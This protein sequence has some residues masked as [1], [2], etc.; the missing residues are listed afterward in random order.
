M[1]SELKRIWENGLDYRL[2]FSNKELSNEERRHF[3]VKCIEEFESFI[4]KK[5]LGQTPK[6][7]QET[8]IAF[9]YSGDAYLFLGN[10]YQSAEYYKFARQFST[11]RDKETTQIPKKEESNISVF[12]INENKQSKIFV[13]DNFYK[14]PDKVRQFALEQTFIE[15]N[16]YYKGFRTTSTFKPNGIKE[17]FENIIGQRISLFDEH[18]FT[19]CFQLCRSSDLQVY[20][21]DQQQWAA[22]IYLTPNAPLQSGTRLHKS[23]IN[24]CSHGTDVGIDDSFSGDFYDST[25]FDIIDSV[26]NVYN[27]LII[28]DAKSIHSAGPYFGS[29]KENCRLTHLFFFD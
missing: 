18:G 6:E 26:G 29:T 10:E 7:D 15:D 19:G 25:K 1:E 9:L 12:E 27:R 4:Y 3:A 17:A 13:V 8:Y 22:M 2:K 14:N 16:R 28:M 20:H 24:E 5:Q 23:K 11:E 21:C